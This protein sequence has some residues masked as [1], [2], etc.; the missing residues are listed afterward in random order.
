[1]QLQFMDCNCRIGAFEAKEEPHF[2][3]L[4]GL[5][6]EMTYLGVADA[7]VMHSWASRWS[8]REGNRKLEELISGRENLRPCYVA[9]PAAT[10]ELAEP[11]EFAAQVRGRKGAVRL[12]PRDHQWDFTPWCAGSLL[13]AL[14][15]RRVPVLI[16]IGQTSWDQVAVVLERYRQLP[17][18]I[19]NTSY[20]VDRHIYPLF[21]AYPNLYLETYTYKMTWGI[22]DISSRFGAD[23]LIFGTGLPETD[24]GGALAQVLYADLSDD[25]KAKIAGGN[26]RR[27]LGL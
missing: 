17:V 13:E 24:G 5:L 6:A 1:M 15:A 12:C 22:E 23:R 11:T 25:E 9:L 16:D 26:L 20:R 3:D 4:D 7:L 18:I 2:T 10:G 27:L 8:P 14:D 19:L 21:Q